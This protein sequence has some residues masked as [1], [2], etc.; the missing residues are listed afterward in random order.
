MIFTQMYICYFVILY[1][2]IIYTNIKILKCC[3]LYNNFTI[4]YYIRIYGLVPI[5]EIQNVIY[6]LHDDPIMDYG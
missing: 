4:I 6:K 1:I 2:P 5:I 3:N